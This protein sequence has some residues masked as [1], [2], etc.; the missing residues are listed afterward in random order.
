MVSDAHAHLSLKKFKADREEVIQRAREAG[1]TWIINVA[2]LGDGAEQ[3][4]ALTAEYDFMPAVVG[5]HPHDAAGFDA[6]RLARLDRLAGREGVVGIGEI[7]L[8]FFRDLS[9]RP[10]QERAFEQQLQLAVNKNL[11]V[12]IHDREAH[13]RTVE[14]VASCCPEKG[15]MFHCFSGDLTLARQVLDL[16]FYV[17]L[18]GVIT[19]PTAKVL[20]EVAAYLP[21]DK[22]L[23][24]TDCPFLAPQPFRG[25]RNEPA[26]VVLVAQKIAQIKGLTYKEVAAQTTANLEKLFGLKAD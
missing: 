10:A 14:I 3:A 18:P 1:L 20:R 25:Q 24:E 7:G 6:G 26:H 11:P 2:M 8:D 4:L 21:L 13:Q 22:L 12:V 5:C 23:V 16:G 17:S 9:P 15:G 19:F